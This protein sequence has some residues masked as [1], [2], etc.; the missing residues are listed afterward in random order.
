[1]HKRLQ[2]RVQHVL[3]HH[4]IYRMSHLVLAH[5]GTLLNGVGG[6][7]DCVSDSPVALKN[8]VVISA[9]FESRGSEEFGAVNMLPACLWRVVMACDDRSQ[10]SA[11]AALAL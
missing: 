8:L 11:T 4:S 7:R 10:H 5:L 9:L 3:T 2:A 1:M 6:A